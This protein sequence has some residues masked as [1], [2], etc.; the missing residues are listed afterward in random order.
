MLL[1]IF[2]IYINFYQIDNYKN[3]GLKINKIEIY[4][5]IKALLEE[6]PIL[7]EEFEE[8]KQFLKK[9]ED[10]SGEEFNTQY[11]MYQEFIDFLLE[12]A[13]IPKNKHVS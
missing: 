8:L 11:E 10:F 5:E 7:R 9:L 1:F 12:I 2:L 3:E 13:S 6:E 4:R